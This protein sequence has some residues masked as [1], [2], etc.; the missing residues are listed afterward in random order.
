MIISLK[1]ISVFSFAGVFLLGSGASGQSLRSQLEARLDQPRFAAA[2]WGVKVVSLDTGKVLFDHNA[3]KLLKPASNAKMYTASLALDRLGP[4]F[5]IRTSFYAHAKPGADGTIHGDL[6]VYGRGDPSMSARFNDGDYAKDFQPVIEALTAAGVKH[7]EGDLIGDDS[8]FRGPPY[9]SEWTWQDLQDYDGAPASALTVQDNVIDLV[10]KPAKTVGDPCQIQTLPQTDIV[11]FSNRTTTISDGHASR[12]RLYR[13]VGQSVAYVWGNVTTATRSLEDAVSVPDPALWF[14]TLL[15]SS[16]AQHGITVDGRPRAVNW[17]DREETPFDPLAWVEVA[18]VLSR[19]LSEIVMRTLKPSQNLYA[20]LLLL[21]VGA[22]S[23]KSDETERSGL[24]E[25]SKFLA[26][27]GIPG[28][29]VLLDEG[30]GLSRGAL[31]TPSASVQLLTFMAHHRYHDA[32][33]NA[34]PIAGVDGTLRNR[35]KGTSAA[36]NVRAK[37]GTLRYVNTLSGYLTTRAGEKLV[38]SVML[39]NY[40]G[41]DGRDEIDRLV[42]SLAAITSR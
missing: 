25:M 18:N 13:P 6:L 29:R 10:F 20:Q 42:E 2:Q 28:G 3:D 17:I 30:S 32:F 24:R 14:V 26:E 19:P 9:G 22:R 15:K 34:L 35:F 31:V 36:G 12:I 21:Q 27:A 7:I 40:T 38:F 23:G 1:K 11:T 41:A 5:R 39:N 33:F 16:L 8:Y 4:D 37:T